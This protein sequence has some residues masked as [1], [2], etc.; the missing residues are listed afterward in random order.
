MYMYSNQSKIPIEKWKFSIASK[1]SILRTHINTS[2]FNKRS[3]L[4]FAQNFKDL[5]KKKSYKN[6]GQNLILNSRLDSIF[7]ILQIL[8][9]LRTIIS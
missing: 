1:D 2:I 7:K 6:S 3:I 8:V 4:I 9:M 5:Y